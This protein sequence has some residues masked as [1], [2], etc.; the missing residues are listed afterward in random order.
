MRNYGKVMTVDMGGATKTK[1]PEL[2]IVGLE[3]E[4]APAVHPV[5]GTAG[6]LNDA[7]SF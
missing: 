7:I 6:K 5:G 1:T 3:G 4:G 2:P